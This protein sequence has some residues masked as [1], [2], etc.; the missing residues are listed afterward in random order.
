MGLRWGSAAFWPFLKP[1]GYRCTDRIVSSRN[2]GTVTLLAKADLNWRPMRRARP[3]REPGPRGSCFFCLPLL[4]PPGPPCGNRGDHP[5]HSSTTINN[6][7]GN[8]MIDPATILL[9]A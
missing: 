2:S 5:E 9:E 6:I 1:G 7:G 8:S 3:E 4:T